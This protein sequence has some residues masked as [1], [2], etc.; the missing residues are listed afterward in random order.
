MYFLI[1]LLYH[2]ILSLVLC[3]SFTFVFSVVRRPGNGDHQ[4]EPEAERVRR[5]AQQLLLPQLLP[6]REL[7]DVDPGLHQEEHAR[8]ALRPSYMYH[9]FFFRVSP[10]ALHEANSPGHMGDVQVLVFKVTH[11]RRLG[12][13]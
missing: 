10:V 6:L 3:C 5:E 2:R 11:A 9:V 7:H 12:L 4:D 13:L 1:A 8:Y